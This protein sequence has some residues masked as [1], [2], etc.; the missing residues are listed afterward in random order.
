MPRG[1]AGEEQCEAELARNSEWRRDKSKERHEERERARKRAWR[2]TIILGRERREVHGTS[3][4]RGWR[5]KDYFRSASLE[6]SH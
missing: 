4:E 5:R 3:R 1:R 6:E 2:Q